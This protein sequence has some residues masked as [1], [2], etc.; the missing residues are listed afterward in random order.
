MRSKFKIIFTSA[1]LLFCGR[2]AFS[3]VIFPITLNSTG[4]SSQINNLMVDYSVSEL[5][6]VQ[7]YSF[8]NN[9]LTQGFLQP[10][11]S[12]ITPLNV[13]IHPCVSPNGDGLGHEVFTV[14]GIENYPNNRM[15]IFD[16][17]G[18][19]IFQ[20]P[21]YNNTDR[22]FSGVA[23]TGLLIDKKE[24]ADGTY[25]YVL[26]VYNAPSPPTTRVYN[27]FLVIKRK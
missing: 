3:Q 22:A 26:E 27:G 5:T 24:A 4:M 15:Q 20:M 2:V 11:T 9:L 23:N 10:F 1:F 17:W 12:F 8:N 18:S 7:T 21:N 6:L 14:D 25:F 19:L 16:R 13:D